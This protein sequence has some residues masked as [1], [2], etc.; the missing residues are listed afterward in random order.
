MDAQVARGWQCV[1]GNHLGSCLELE[2]FIAVYEMNGACSSRF[3][4]ATADVCLV[5]I[6]YAVH[7]IRAKIP[8]SG[9]GRNT[10]HKVIRGGF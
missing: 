7:N 4:L 3:G 8:I 2:S 1:T 9:I 10:P 5:R 6:V